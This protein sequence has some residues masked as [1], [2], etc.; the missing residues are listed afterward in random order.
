MVK[1][2]DESDVAEEDYGP[3]EALLVLAEKPQKENVLWHEYQWRMC[4]SY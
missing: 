4:V 3:W 1:S 2:L